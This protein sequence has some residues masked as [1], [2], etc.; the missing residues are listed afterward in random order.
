[1]TE[2]EIDLK[3]VLQLL[4]PAEIFEYFEIILIDTNEK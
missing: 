2:K 4:L 1:M 3:D